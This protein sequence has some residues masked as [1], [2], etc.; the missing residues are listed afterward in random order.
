MSSLIFSLAVWAKLQFWR[1]RIGYG[2]IVYDKELPAFRLV[3]GEIP[4]AGDVREFHFL[5]NIGR[6]RWRR[7]L[8]VVA[9]PRATPR[10][11]WSA[12]S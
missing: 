2:T 4:F 12:P 1:L 8:M 6:L 7:F 3:L 5:E 10:W 11:L 9:E